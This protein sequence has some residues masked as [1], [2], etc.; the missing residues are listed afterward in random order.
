MKKKIRIVSLFSGIG[1]FEQGFKNSKINYEVVFESEIDKN[2]IITYGYNFSLNNMH[3]DI[4]MIDENVVPEHDLLCAGFP[5]QSFS[6]AGKQKGFEDIRGTLFFDVIRII[7]VKTPK[8]ILLENVK[9]LVLHDGGATIKTIL[10]NISDCGYSF[11]ITIINSKEAG[12]PQGRERTYIVG[13]YNYRSEPFEDDRRSEKINAIKKWANS[14]NLRTINFFN[15]ITMEKRQQSIIDI[16][17]PTVKDKYYINSDKVK[18]YIDNL[19]LSALK[20]RKE[21]KILKEFDIPRNIFN[22]LERQRRVYS[23]YGLSPTLLARSDSPKIIIKDN[24][25]YIIR[26][27]TPY[28][29][30]RIQGFDENYVDNVK[31]RGMSDTQLYKQSGNAVSPPIISQIANALKEIIDE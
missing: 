30:L 21:S 18:N 13:V 25:S 22:D 6:I 23:I 1:G 11:D 26:K 9:N 7:K 31:S 19:D 10:K 16:L 4:K 29:T 28:E 12:V 27:L 3:G 20:T 14:N 8:Y 5:C 15:K 24:N 17:D 2:A